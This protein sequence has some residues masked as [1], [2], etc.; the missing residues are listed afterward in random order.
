MLKNKGHD[1]EAGACVQK[2]MPKE[3]KCDEGGQK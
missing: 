2:P 3:G 1:G